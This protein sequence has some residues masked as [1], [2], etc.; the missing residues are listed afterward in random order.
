[1]KSHWHPRPPSCLG[2]RMATRV[3]R[4]QNTL[5]S[6]DRPV[7]TLPLLRRG[8]PSS[9][10][11]LSDRA[12]GDGVLLN[13]C[14]LCPFSS[15]T[16]CYRAGLVKVTMSIASCIECITPETSLD[17]ISVDK[18]RSSMFP[19]RRFRQNFLAFAARGIERAMHLFRGQKPKPFSPI[20]RA[21]TA[22]QPCRFSRA[23]VS[24][25]IAAI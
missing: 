11:L 5:R 25:P 22:S 12:T 3:L 23:S 15:R 13:E 6:L 16:N 19:F 17:G 2:N 14:R 21:R 1:M 24:G 4:A 9:S 7:I 10:L 8:P 18:P 20:P